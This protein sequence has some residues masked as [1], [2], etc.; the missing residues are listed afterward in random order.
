[1]KEE[2]PPFK[3]H[4]LVCTY[5]DHV[6]LPLTLDSVKD[7]CDSIIIADGAYKTYYDVYKAFDSSVRPW[8]TDGTLEIIKA[9]EPHLPPVKLIGAPNG[10]PWPNQVVKRNALVDAVPTQDWFLVLDSDELFY[11]DIEAGVNEIMASGCVCGRVPL[12][13]VG[14]EI[15]GWLPFWH[16]RIFMKLP[17]MHY[18][19]KHWLLSDSDNRVLENEYPMWATDK[20]CL[21]HLK[22][23]R[24]QRRLA[25]HQ[26]YMDK[27]SANGWVEPKEHQKHLG[28]PN[29]IDPEMFEVEEVN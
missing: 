2:N 10:K 21:A 3:I 23:F 28:K 9:L 12:Y 14:L 4:C 13:N 5:N 22:I 27:L 7:V 8:S 24:D 25:P 6:A 11:G 15:E 20:F 19:R 1:L 16:P 18:W 26:K 29:D 17:G